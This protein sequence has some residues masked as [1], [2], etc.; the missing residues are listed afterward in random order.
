MNLDLSV[1]ANPKAIAP[2]DASQLTASVAGGRPPYSFSWS[3]VAGSSVADP[4]AS[5]AATTTYT[6]TVI[7]ADGAIA[8][9]AVTVT[10]NP[11]AGLAACFNVTP[12][13]PVVFGLFLLDASCSTGAVSYQW[14]LTPPGE[15]ERTIPP[16]SNPLLDFV[17][18]SVGDMLIRLQV[19]DAVGNVDETS[20][21]IPIAP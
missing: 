2:G 18:A 15:A 3:L 7:D 17:S 14:F 21:T 11:T 16:S 20:Q 12:P 13:D 4:T 6:A 19:L 10:V 8:V 1:T 5:P 9:D